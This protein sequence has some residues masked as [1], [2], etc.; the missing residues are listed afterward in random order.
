MVEYEQKQSGKREG[1]EEQPDPIRKPPPNTAPELGGSSAAHIRPAATAENEIKEKREEAFATID[2]IKEGMW[3]GEKLLL[4]FSENNA[5]QAQWLTSWLATDFMARYASTYQQI[6][7]YW[8][9]PSD[10]L[11]ILLQ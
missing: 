11:L 3:K 2:W 6:V 9:S 1:G 4:M 5:P 10:D 7:T 8:L